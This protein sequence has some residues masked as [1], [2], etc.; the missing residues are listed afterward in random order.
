MAL[1][2]AA[3]MT[4]VRGGDGGSGTDDMAPVRSSVDI[5]RSPDFV[6]LAP[7]ARGT[8]K[9][10]EYPQSRLRGKPYPGSNYNAAAIAFYEAMRSTQ[11]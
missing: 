11:L 7:E 3:G 4:L 1:V 2:A 9:K 8:R 6:A 5:Q 10:S